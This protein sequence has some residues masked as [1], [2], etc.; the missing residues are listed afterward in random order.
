MICFR[1]KRNSTS[2]N[3]TKY[4]YNNGA[5]AR[6]APFGKYLKK[7]VSQ[8]CNVCR[9]GLVLTH[10]NARIPSAKKGLLRLLFFERNNNTLI[11]T[12]C[13]IPINIRRSK[14]EN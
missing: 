13:V 14:S 9:S 5:I 2:T 4:K 10:D 12:P 6:S 1:E 7:G 8:R 3:E 11:T